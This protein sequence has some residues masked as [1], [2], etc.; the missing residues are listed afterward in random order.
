VIEVARGADVLVVA[1]DGSADAGP[2]SLGRAGRFIVDHAP[3][4]VLLVPGTPGPPG[5]PPSL[6]SGAR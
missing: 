2:K 5:A 6:P 1:R 3:C 4:P